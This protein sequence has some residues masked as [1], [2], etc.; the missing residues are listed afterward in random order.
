[1]SPDLIA[2]LTLA[3][4][5]AV[6]AAVVLAQMFRCRDGS[7]LWLLYALDRIYV[8]LVFHWRANR[9]CPFPAQGAALIIANHS[10]PLDPMLIWTNHH[11]G[12][13]KRKVRVISFLMAREYYE[14]TGVNIISRIMKAIPLSRDGRDV[15]P[16]R[17]ALRRLRGGQLVGVFPEG[18]INLQR[19]LLRA[20]TGLA[21]LAIKSRAPVYPVFIHGV[22]HGSNMIEPFLTPCRAR[23]SYGPPIDLSRHYARKAT[24]PL[25]R[26]VT[27]QLMH[28]L[29]ALGGVPYPLPEGDDEVDA[30]VSVPI[31]ASM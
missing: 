1:M 26:E 6:A 20:D 23:L 19:G 12:S 16:V 4:Y 17:E 9:R 13:P 11:L 29:A 28:K 22:P 21:W 2:Q 5:A 24:Q 10:S 18:R 14:T 30:T 3:G 25:L 15:G 8:G 31:R 27:D 7:L